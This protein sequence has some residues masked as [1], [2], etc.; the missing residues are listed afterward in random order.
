MSDDVSIL[1]PS[2]AAYLR[3]R[4]D[5]QL[6]IAYTLNA[7]R[8]LDTDHLRR[9]EAL[10]R[11]GRYAEVIAEVKRRIEPSRQR[12]RQV[13]SD[14]AVSPAIRQI[15]PKGKI[16]RDSCCGDRPCKRQ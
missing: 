15:M 3:A 2:D 13:T 9:I 14:A 7:A 5:D 11:A 4:A 6:A 12:P 16:C 10:N 8:Q 1:H